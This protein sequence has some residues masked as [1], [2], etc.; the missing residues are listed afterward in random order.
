MLS[1]LNHVFCQNSIEASML[2]SE[3]IPSSKLTVF[4]LGYSSRLFH[5]NPVHNSSSAT[6]RTNDV[7]IVGGCTG[8]LYYMRRKNTDFVVRL[9][10][11]LLLS[12]PSIRIT[13]LGR[14]WHSLQGIR[15][16]NVTCLDLQHSLYHSVYLD[17]KLYLN[18]SMQ[19]AGPV[20]WLEAMACGCYILSTPSGFS[21]ELPNSSLKAWTMPFISSIDDWTQRVHALL[22]AYRGIDPAD[23]E[24]RNAFLQRSEFSKLSVCLES[25]LFPVK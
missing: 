7:L 20:S 21:L 16:L 25:T 8:S 17:S 4:P 3:G 24:L 11:S 23:M 10:R 12:R 19:E 5:F 1:R 22:A 13:L 2:F 6:C 9:I 14:G 15:D 18:L